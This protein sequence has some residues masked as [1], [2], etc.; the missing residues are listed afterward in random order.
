M[1]VIIRYYNTR[2]TAKKNIYKPSLQ[3]NV[4]KQ[5]ISFMATDTWQDLPTHLKNS[6]VTA[7]PKKIIC[8]LLSEQQMK[9]FVDEV[10]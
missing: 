6:N 9:Q 2:Y 4:S 5:S 7:F 1:L 10:T 8:F 3:T